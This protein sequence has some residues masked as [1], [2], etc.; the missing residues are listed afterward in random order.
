MLYSEGIKFKK[1]N[2]ILSFNRDFNLLVETPIG[3]S[4]RPIFNP[5]GF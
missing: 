2:I 4:T 3:V 1:C 5:P